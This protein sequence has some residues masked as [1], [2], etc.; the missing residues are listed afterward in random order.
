M[1]SSDTRRF[2]GVCR[3]YGQANF[4][5]LTQ[6]HVTIIGLGGVG[7]WCAEA[8]ARTH[9]GKLTLID[10]DTIAESNINRQLPALESTIGR[11]KAEVLA[12]RFAQINPNVQ[13]T[14]HVA[15]V[16]ETNLDDLIPEDGIIVDA[17][18]SLKAKAALIAWAKT[19]KRSIVVSGGAGGRT[20]PSRITTADLSRTTADA[21]L[22]KLRTQLRKDY[23]FPKGASNPKDSRPFGITAVYSTE[24]GRAC[25]PDAL[26]LAGGAQA[27]FGTAMVVTASLGLR[28]AQVVISRV[29]QDDAQNQG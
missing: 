3:L 5:R 26:E 8:L 4:E 2:G 6:A 22:S 20:D 10:A 14:T 23:N 1:N 25:A 18:D 16:D 29:L 28:V 12:E 21:L 7:S 15:F 9:I 17:I 13:I 27:G 11:P 24:M 19:K